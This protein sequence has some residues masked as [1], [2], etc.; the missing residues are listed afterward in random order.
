MKNKRVFAL[1]IALILTAV[2]V[3]SAFAEETQKGT[4]SLDGDNITLSWTRTT[5]CTP[6]EMGLFNWKKS[7]TWTRSYSESGS[8]TFSVNNDSLV[9]RGT[10]FSGTYRIPR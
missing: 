3:G 5:I 4:Y 1:G 8:G 6:Y 7:P 10:V 9:I 2:I